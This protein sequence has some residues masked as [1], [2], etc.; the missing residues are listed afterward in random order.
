[1]NIIQNRMSPIENLVSSRN[2]KRVDNACFSS[3][4]DELQRYLNKAGYW[5]EQKDCQ[6][7][8]TNFLLELS[9]ESNGKYNPSLWFISVAKKRLKDNLCLLET[10]WKN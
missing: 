1:M 3:V 6:R 4:Y 8:L 7:L 5:T 9:R 2:A 10:K